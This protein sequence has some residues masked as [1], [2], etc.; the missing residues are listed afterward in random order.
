[1]MRAAS[2]ERSRNRCHAPVANLE[3]RRR[4]HPAVGGQDP[5]RR[6]QRAERDHAGR[7][8]V[9]ALADAFQAEQHHAEEARFEEECGEHL[10]TH[11]R[12]KDRT[13]AV[14]ERTP[15]GAELVAHDDARHHA[16]AEGER[17]NLQPVAIQHQVGVTT[18]PQ[19]QRFEHR[20][21]AREPDRECRKDDVK[22]D[23]E[24]ELQARQE[25][26]IDEVGHCRNSV[27]CM[28][29]GGRTWQSSRSLMYRGS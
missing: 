21:V 3:P 7:E 14:R 19:P 20:E 23:R 16:H 15:V 9:Q 28:A 2:F 6:D 18:A 22:R 29:R 8:E 10:V 26:G 17:E 25:C 24:R 4:V 12:S 11:E 27:L 13:G 5:E 1:M